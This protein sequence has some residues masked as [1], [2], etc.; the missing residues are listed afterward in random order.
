V[1]VG[2]NFT[3]SMILYEMENATSSEIKI[4]ILG[5]IIII[6]GVTI[7]VKKNGYTVE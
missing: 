5:I 6:I 3:G 2:W 4:Q 1:I 7:L